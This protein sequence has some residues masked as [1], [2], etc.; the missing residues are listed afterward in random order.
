M[1]VQ[2]ANILLIED[3][4]TDAVLIERMLRRMESKI[5]WVKSLAGAI[6]AIGKTE[7]DLVLTDLG[8]PDSSGIEIVPRLRKLM[9]TSPII[10]LTGSDDDRQG[11]AAINV[12]ADDYLPKSE[13]SESI[14][15]RAVEFSIQ[16]VELTRQIVDANRVLERKNERLARMY[17]MSQQFVDNVS[18]EFRTPLTVIREFASIVRDG[19]DGP[20]TE[21]QKNRLSTLMCRAD[22]LSGMVNDLLDTSRLEAG[23]VK[24]YRKKHDLAEVVAQVKKMLVTR[25]QA[26]SISLDIRG[27]PAGMD[28]F[29]DEEKLRRVLVNLVVNA[30]KFTPEN[31]KIRVY[32][33]MADADRVQVTVADNGPGIA[34]DELSR[35]FERFQQAEVHHRMASCKGFGLGLSIARALASLN[36]GSLHVESVEGQGSQFSVMVPVAN[37]E[38]VLRCYFGQRVTMDQA[39]GKMTAFCIRTVDPLDE[40]QDEGVQDT[41]DEFMRSSVKS[42]DLVLKVKP[43]VWVIYMCASGKESEVCATRI[44]TEWERLRRNH[45]GNPLPDLMIKCVSTVEVAKGLEALLQWAHIDALGPVA[46][47]APE[48]A[49]GPRLVVIED[50]FEVADAIRARLRANGFDVQVAHDGVEGIAAVEQCVPKAI[51]LD[52]RMPKMDGLAVLERLRANEETAGIPVVVLSASLADK[53]TVLDRGARFFVQKPFASE[54]LLKALDRAIE[55]SQ[56]KKT[57]IAS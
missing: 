6:D 40:D 11:V 57:N 9:E 35:I 37:L 17:Q 44:A 28:V 1:D 16:R 10:V 26:K 52:V 2:P 12:G 32:A 31:G 18:H 29:C 13:M 21:E 30:I 48:L 15:R 49:H 51:V 47:D 23:L 56:S 46:S 38:S 20:V 55:D 54:A 43:G 34:P 45:Y 39:S 22:D 3:T 24:T 36:L 5:T 7:F 33:A 53:Q 27:V 19:I 4:E 42:Y 8:L 14:I 41:I 25:A 50:E